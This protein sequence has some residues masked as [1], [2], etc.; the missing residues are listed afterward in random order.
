MRLFPLGCAVT[1]LG[2][3]V[4]WVGLAGPPASAVPIDDGRDDLYDILLDNGGVV[5][6]NGMSASSN[7][8]TFT[9][10]RYTSLSASAPGERTYK[11][12]DFNGDRKS[13][14]YSIDR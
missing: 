5:A 7:F 12:A 11:L 14:L 8:A 9:S 6:L 2:P 4:A 3:L 13:D 1:L 10:A